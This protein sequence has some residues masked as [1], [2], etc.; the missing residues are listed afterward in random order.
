MAHKTA[1]TEAPTLHALVI[2]VG[3][4]PHFEGG[5]RTE[6]REYVGMRQ[7]TSPVISAHKVVDWL[8]HERDSAD[9]PLGSLEVL[10][11]SPEH[12]GIPSPD[13]TKMR[14]SAPTMSNLRAAVGRWKRAAEKHPDNQSLF[15]F[16][17]HGLSAG[18]N[19]TLLLEDF[20]RRSQ[21][22]FAGAINVPGFLAAM[23]TSKV[24]NQLY[25]FD[26]C[27]VDGSGRLQPF[28]QYGD[29]LVGPQEAYS[30]QAKQVSLW[31][32]SPMRAA[33][34]YLDGRAS[35]F[36]EAVIAALRGA[37][38][39]RVRGHFQVSTS[40]LKRAIDTYV[41]TRAPE[42]RQVVDLR[43]MTIDF[44]LGDLL[45]PVIPVTVRCHT[46]TLNRDAIFSYWRSPRIEGSEA[47]ETRARGH[48]GPWHTQVALGK[49]CFGAEFDDAAD[50]KGEEEAYPPYLH[51]EFPR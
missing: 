46:E 32:S 12:F 24:P 10:V 34:G 15:Y 45:E 44:P 36:A 40:S 25:F 13:G 33:R 1:A 29:S 20:G 2:G 17:G 19:D 28:Q 35:V 6:R 4:Y 30:G 21:N 47:V 9:Y 3:H 51:V 43:S 49:Y 42:A 31:A 11:S 38:A 7:L 14:V 26:A 50:Y 27:M 16:C 41:R 22:H 5:G 48:D 37:A 8:L 23:Q 39:E 18:F